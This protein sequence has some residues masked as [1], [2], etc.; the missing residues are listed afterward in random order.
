MPEFNIGAET[1][2][3]HIGSI[4]EVF[5]TDPANRFFFLS[6]LVGLEAIDH[7]FAGEQIVTHARFENKQVL[8]LANPW[9]RLRELD[10]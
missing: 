8:D 2:S 1:Q 4:Y 9:L 7:K 5:N 10:L 3:L 6:E